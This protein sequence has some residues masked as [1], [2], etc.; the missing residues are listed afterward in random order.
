MKNSYDT[1]IKLIQFYQLA[2]FGLNHEEADLGSTCDDSA[3]R[4]LAFKAD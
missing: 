2:E 4:L 3:S 1:D